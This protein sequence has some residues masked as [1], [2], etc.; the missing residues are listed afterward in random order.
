MN[1]SQCSQSF[2]AVVEEQS[3]SAAA[4][5]R[6]R[7]SPQISKEINWLEDELGVPLLV[8]TTRKLNLTEA[9]EQFYQYA[10]RSLNEYQEIKQMLHGNEI[11]LA[12]KLTITMPVAFGEWVMIDML[13]Q[14]MVQ[15]PNIELDLKL[16]NSFIDLIK[17]GIDLGLRTEHPS[18]ASYHCELLTH[19]QRRIYCTKNYLKKYGEPKNPADLKNHF[20][21]IHTSMTNPYRWGFKNNQ[22]VLV[23]AKMQC[24]NIAN[25]LHAAKNDLGFVYLSELQIKYHNQH[26]KTKLVSVLDDYIIPPTPVYLCYPKKAYLP[27]KLSYFIEYARSQFTSISKLQSSS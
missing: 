9:G 21:L 25:L 24:N 11:A 17:E 16:T 8:R 27:Q 18:N 22:S 15:H 10:K 1:L 12:G 5:K 13:T 26:N 20:C 2:I 3:F 19:V 14:F 6:F 7:S 23:K 4:R